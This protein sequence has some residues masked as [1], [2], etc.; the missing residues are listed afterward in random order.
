MTKFQLNFLRFQF[1]NQQFRELALFLVLF[2]VALCQMQ[3]LG[4]WTRLYIP[5]FVSIALVNSEAKFQKNISELGINNFVQVAR[6]YGNL[7][8]VTIAVALVKNNCTA[9]AQAFLLKFQRMLLS[10]KWLSLV[11]HP[12]VSLINLVYLWDNLFPHYLPLLV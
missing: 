11:L 5:I 9:L 1:T 7:L 12:L 3:N 6:T 2:T 10:I 8:V 4:K